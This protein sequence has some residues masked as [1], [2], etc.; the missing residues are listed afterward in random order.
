MNNAKEKFKEI[1]R[2][3]SKIDVILESISFWEARMNKCFAECDEIE[4]NQWLP[5]LDEKTSALR[6]EMQFILNKVNAEERELD[7]L[8]EGI[9]KLYKEIISSEI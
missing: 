5:N 3:S 4:E 1:E 7:I 2:L 8:D 9:S 6:K